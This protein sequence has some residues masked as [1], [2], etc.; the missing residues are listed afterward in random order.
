MS[1]S[2]DVMKVIKSLLESQRF[3]VLATNDQEQP[4]LFLMAFAA[5]DDLKKIVFVTERN[6]H[7]YI[8][9]KSNQRVALLMDDRENRG[10][11]TRDA[12]A[13][14]VL[15]EADEVEGNEA[16]HLRDLYLARHPYLTEFAQSPSCAIMRVRVKSY[17]IVRKFQEVVEWCPDHSG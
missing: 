4:Y 2:E 1:S 17:Q 8:Y 3:A 14:T 7:K 10:S 16:N 15:G 11:D 9:L 6:T 5:A 12:V 13:I